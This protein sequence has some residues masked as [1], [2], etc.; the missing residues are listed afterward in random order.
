[1]ELAKRQA[2]KFLIKSVIIPIVAHKKSCKVGYGFALSFTKKPAL[3]KLLEIRFFSF[4]LV[5]K[6]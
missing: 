1:M 4:F 5:S 2:T 3:L 6:C